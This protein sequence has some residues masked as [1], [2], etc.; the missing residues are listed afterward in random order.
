MR[1]SRRPRESS[2]RPSRGNEFRAI[3]VL[4][5][6][7]WPKGALELRGRVVLAL[8]LLVGAK[9]TNVYVPMFYRDAVN[10]LTGEVGAV[11]ALPI[12]LLFAYGLARLFAI[13]FGEMRDAVFAKVVQRAMRASALNTFR[14]LHALSLRYHLDR[15]TGGSQ[16][17]GKCLADRVIVVDDVEKRGCWVH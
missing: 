14:H 1:S 4:L 8:V 17:A 12:G 9:A 15:Q 6:Y 2:E 13:A 7:L 11:I 3:P 16:Q 5:P 10:I